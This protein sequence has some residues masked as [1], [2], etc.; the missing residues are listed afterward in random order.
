MLVDLV[1]LL[2]VLMPVI[3]GALCLGVRKKFTRDLVVTITVFILIVSSLLLYGMGGV[4]YTPAPIYGV[5]ILILDFG[6]LL[7]FLLEGIKY[8]D[9]LVVILALLQ[10]V[11]IAFFELFIGGGH[12]E[13]VFIVDN[14]SKIMSLIISIVG[15]MVVIY[16][17]SYMEEHERHLGMVESKQPRFF[18]FML[19]LLGAMHGLVFSNN[20]YWLYFFWEITTLCS[21]ELIRHD[22][23]DV[24][25]ENSLT[26]LWMNLV[27]GVA[28]V[29]FMFIGNASLNSIALQE[30][31]YSPQLPI[32]LIGFAVIAIAAFSKS[33]LLPFNK[34][35]QGAMVAPTPVSALLHSSTM[36]NAGVYLLLRIAPG[37]RGTKLSWGIAFL[38]G[39]TFLVTSV[40]A[41]GERVSKGILA[42]STIGNLG[43][44]TLCVGINTPLSYSAAI[45]LL[46]FHSFSK[47]FL[48]LGAGVIENRV[49]SRLIEDWEGLL[50][51]LPFTSIMMIIGMFS[52][53]LPPFGML[54][55]KWAAIG[56]LSSASFTDSILLIILIVIG[57][58]ATSLFYAKWL[59]HLTILPLERRRLNF[60]ELS[61]PY[62]FSM[63]S[64]M[65]INIVIG[66][67]AVLLIRNTVLPALPTGYITP[68]IAGWLSIDTGVSTFPI[69][70]FYVI[71]AAIIIL[72][73]LVSRLKGGEIKTS[74]VSGEN[75]SGS[76]ISFM[77][78]ADTTAEFEV[79][80]MFYDTEIGELRLGMYAQV[81]GLLVNLVILVLAVL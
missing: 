80:G 4:K 33:A 18:F 43:L 21:Y 2:T 79:T 25:I 61:T 3:S 69:L 75:V 60:E 28:F 49:H 45:L 50:A 55:G 73:V 35:L 54:F 68:I 14:L 42:F 12:S 58:S 71:S 30:L 19:L 24:S 81:I 11:P 57:S 6:L 62:V 46:I 65:S 1:F 15:G 66:S 29:A 10:L 70:P 17:T 72:G 34:W 63:V 52:M 77:T 39:L 53:F 36:V 44:M 78:T 13:P 67:C 47:G 7:Y 8:R 41:I 22:G 16:A 51:R 59:G 9:P 37:I 64:L 74:Y 27:G 32:T 38:G 40:F 76:P 23:T 56:A 48:F 20:I 26:A 5:I 31:I